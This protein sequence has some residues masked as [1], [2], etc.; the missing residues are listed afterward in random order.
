M[1]V[2]KE[3]TSNEKDLVKFNLIFVILNFFRRFGCVKIQNTYKMTI[4]ITNMFVNV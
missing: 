4:T 1:L 2:K 3:T